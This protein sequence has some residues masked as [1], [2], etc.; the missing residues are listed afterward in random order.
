MTRFPALEGKEVVAVLCREDLVKN[1][2][3]KAKT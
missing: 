2:K 1:K 3:R